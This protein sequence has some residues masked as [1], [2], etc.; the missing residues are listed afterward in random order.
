MGLYDMHTAV[1]LAYLQNYSGSEEMVYMYVRFGTWEP[2]CELMWSLKGSERMLFLYDA[3]HKL[4]G[5]NNK[6]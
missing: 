5:C 2:P 6:Y 1:R 3:R 4:R